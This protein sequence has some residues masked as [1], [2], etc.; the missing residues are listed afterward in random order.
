MEL[1]AL[2]YVSHGRWE[3]AERKKWKKVHY[4]IDRYAEQL[5]SGTSLLTIL[6]CCIGISKVINLLQ[7]REEIGLAGVTGV[8]G[9]SKIAW[10]ATTRSHCAFTL[11]A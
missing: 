2:L 5:V 4:F 9:H 10:H 6:E 8:T 11:H 1:G 3:M 7:R